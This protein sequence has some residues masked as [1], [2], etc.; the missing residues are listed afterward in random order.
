MLH[1]R[2]L[3]FLPVVS[4]AAE[5]IR[6]LREIGGIAPRLRAVLD[7][8]I[9]WIQQGRAAEL[10]EATGLHAEIDAL[11]PEIDA[12]AGW[13]SIVL[14][15]LLVRLGSARYDA[16]RQRERSDRDKC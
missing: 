7:H 8:M 6:L 4:G 10:S 9:A 15:G 1:Q 12:T 13:K 2:V 5:R 14:A 3:L 16:V 11:E